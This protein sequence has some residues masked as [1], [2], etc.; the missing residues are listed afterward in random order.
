MNLENID[1]ILLALDDE[2][3]KT[4]VDMKQFVIQAAANLLHNTPSQCT[5]LEDD[6]D[7]NLEHSIQIWEDS[8]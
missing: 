7:L 3:R 5:C 8:E 6:L 1:S 4:A 2:K